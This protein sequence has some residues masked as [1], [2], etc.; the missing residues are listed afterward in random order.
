MHTSILPQAATVTTGII[1]TDA[2]VVST[3]IE[4]DL[5]ITTDQTSGIEAVTNLFRFSKYLFKISV[6]MWNVIYII[7]FCALS[8]ILLANITLTSTILL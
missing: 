5:L 2:G 4:V 7:T 3:I 6:Q 8:A 1:Q